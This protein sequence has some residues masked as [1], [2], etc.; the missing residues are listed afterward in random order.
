MVATSW[1][2]SAMKL[3]HA[4]AEEMKGNCGRSKFPKKTGVRLGPL[5]QE[6]EHM[7]GLELRAKFYEFFHSDTRR[8]EDLAWAKLAAWLNGHDSVLR[9]R[10]VALPPKER[11]GLYRFMHESLN[12]RIY[13]NRC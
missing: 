11:D 2:D 5:G 3:R 6:G 7:T 10:I 1:Y 9:E 13:D 12:C 8:Q 4:D